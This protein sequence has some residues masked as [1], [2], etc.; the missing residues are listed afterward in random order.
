MRIP[1]IIV[2][3]T[4]VLN[5]PIALS[6]ALTHHIVHVLRKKTQDTVTLANADGAYQAQL[7]YQEE[8]LMAIPTQYLHE[9]PKITLQIHLYQ[10]S[11][12]SKKMEL[13]FQKATELGVD[14]ITI[15]N[16]E[17][18]Q[19][20]ADTTNWGKKQQRYQE[21]IMSASQQCNAIQYQHCIL[22]LHLMPCPQAA[23][24]LLLILKAHKNCAH[25]NL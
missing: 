25:Y 3:Q 12:R 14:A 23:N 11:C 17:R 6:Q 20:M 21:I 15:V 2:T 19:V 24:G 18:S 4:I 13:I 10:A 5:V 1:Y 7:Q 16:M 8:K 22:L 9:A